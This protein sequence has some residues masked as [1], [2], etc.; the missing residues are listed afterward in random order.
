MCFNIKV[1]FNLLQAVLNLIF[2]I[3]SSFE[4]HFTTIMVSIME[5]NKVVEVNSSK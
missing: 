2:K 3:A 5:F 4:N 1:S